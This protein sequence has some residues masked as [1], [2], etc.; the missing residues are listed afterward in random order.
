M[1]EPVFAGTCTALVTPFDKNGAIDFDSFDKLIENQL[2]AGV[3]ALC[4]CGTTGE[5]PSL[6]YEEH[7]EL[8]AHCVGRVDHRVK[9]IAGTG[10]NNTRSAV[11]L[12]QNAQ[13]AGADALLIVTPYYNKATQDGLIRHYTYIA[14]RVELPIILYNV[15]SRTGV[16]FAAET[17]RTLAENPRING[18]KEAS[19]NLALVTRTRAICGDDFHIWS[20]NDDQ[21]V[22]LMSLGAQGVVSA[23]ANV[24]PAVMADM[25]HYCQAGDFTAAADLQVDYAQLLEALYSEVN[26]IPI[27]SA[28]ALMG[29]CGDTLRLPLSPISATHKE[30]LQAAME[31]VGLL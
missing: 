11:K 8:V 31:R 4:V 20:G 6:S 15:P 17:Y 18:V 13:D 23:A 24:I 21:V 25:A 7:A 30:A 12:S 3:D 26:P 29:I 1:R 16:S 22:P 5:S 9:V 19:G 10:S 27:K 14:D 28:L 2:A